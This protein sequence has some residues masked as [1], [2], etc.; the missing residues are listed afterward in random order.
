MT[1]GPSILLFERIQSPRSGRLGGR[2][3]LSTATKALAWWT[4]GNPSRRIR[5]PTPSGP[6]RLNHRRGAICRDDLP[7]EGDWVSTFF[8][9]NSGNLFPKPTCGKYGT[10]RGRDR[11]RRGTGLVAKQGHS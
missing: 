8:F 10:I 6:P 5:R 4:V 3:D 11:D 9:L 2:R 7:A 1:I